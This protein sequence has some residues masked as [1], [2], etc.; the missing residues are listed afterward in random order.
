MRSATRVPLV[1]PRSDEPRGDPADIRVELGE[2][3][4]RILPIGAHLDDG[5]AVVAGPPVESGPQR[6]P[7]LARRDLRHRALELIHPCV[8][9]RCDVG[10]FRC[11]V[12]CTD[13]PVDIGVR[14]TC[15]EVPQIEVGEHR[16]R[17]PPQQQRRQI[18][19][20]L[21]IGSDVDRGQ[22]GLDDPR[23]AVCLQRMRQWRRAARR[24][25]R[26]PR[27]PLGW[28]GP[29]EVWSMPWSRE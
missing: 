2:R 28:V 4:L 16:I 24:F 14:Q 26:E 18:A 21:E 11:E 10:I 20:L 7:P 23:R 19:Q 5:D 17:G 27:T 8:D 25:D 9:R 15:S 3:D 13:E 1:T 12:P 22:A 6:F 29:L